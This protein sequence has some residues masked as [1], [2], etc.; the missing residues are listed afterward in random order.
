MK[1]KL[2]IQNFLLDKIVFRDHWEFPTLK[3]NNKIFIIKLFSRICYVSALFIAT[4]ANVLNKNIIVSVFHILITKIYGI[5]DFNARVP[6]K[7]R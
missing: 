3:M 4:M 6:Q 7:F 5:S 1:L 2:N